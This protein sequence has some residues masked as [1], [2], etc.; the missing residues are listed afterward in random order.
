MVVKQ[1]GL[2][3]FCPQYFAYFFSF[4]FFLGAKAKVGTNSHPFLCP[5]KRNMASLREGEILGQG[6]SEERGEEARS[7]IFAGA[8][9]ISG[10]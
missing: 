1:R 8:I 6:A 3:T 2:G 7:S 5:W 4:L 9:A 10:I